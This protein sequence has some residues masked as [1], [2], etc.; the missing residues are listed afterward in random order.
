MRKEIQP[1]TMDKYPLITK[2]KDYKEGDIPIQL[3]TKSKVMSHIKTLLIMITSATILV[4]APYYMG[5]WDLFEITTEKNGIMGR[6]FLG[7]LSIVIV[8]V[9]GFLLMILGGIIYTIYNSILDSF[10]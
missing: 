10:D 7:L 1:H 4:F 3:K 9:I 2:M 5:V 8:G 6:W